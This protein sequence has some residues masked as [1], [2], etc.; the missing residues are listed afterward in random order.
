MMASDDSSAA[1][2]AR[3]A[4]ILDHAITQLKPDD[5]V[6]ILLRFFELRDLKSIGQVLGINEDTAQKRVSRALDK[7]RAILARQGIALSAA[8]LG[9]ALTSDTLAAAPATLAGTIAAAA[10]TSTATGPGTTVALSKTLIMSKAIST[11]LGAIMIVGMCGIIVRQHGANESLRAEVA[12][13]KVHAESMPQASQPAPTPSVPQAFNEEMQPSGN[14][15]ELLRLRGQIGSMTRELLSLRSNQAA[16]AKLSNM[17]VRPLDLDQFPDSHSLIRASV[18]TNAGTATPAALLQTWLWAL[19]T[20][21]PDGLART[22]DWPEGTSEAAKQEAVNQEAKSIQERGSTVP[23]NEPEDFRLVALWPIGEDFYVATFRQSNFPTFP[24]SV[25]R[26]FFRKT[27]DGWKV[28]VYTPPQGA[29]LKPDGK[30]L[31][32]FN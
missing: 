21:D 15:A 5:R 7:L 6:A 32:D 1:S 24:D 3:I 2:L 4:P 13:L 22:K 16:L 26:Q 20:G 12:R 23:Q 17:L 18:A 8:A 19:R 27:E 11:I 31:L 25:G 28:T 14:Q 9:T 29:F 30:R 10:L